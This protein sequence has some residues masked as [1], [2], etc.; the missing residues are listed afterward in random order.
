MNCAFDI[1]AQAAAASGPPG[2]DAGARFTAL[3]Q[4]CPQAPSEVY[5]AT[6]MPAAESTMA[7]AMELLHGI[8]NLGRPL[9][10][11][12]PESTGQDREASA[13]DLYEDVRSAN[14]ELLAF[15]QDL[16]RYTLMLETVNST[17]Q[18]VSTLFQMQG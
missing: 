9:D 16:F 10:H 1:A 5:V 11:Y 14:T 6:A 15:Q 13:G 2:G 7:P 18:G 17:K 3:L 4:T 12:A 8:E